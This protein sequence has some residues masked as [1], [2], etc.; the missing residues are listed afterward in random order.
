MTPFPLMFATAGLLAN[1]T[2]AY[3]FDHRP[4]QGREYWGNFTHTV[5]NNSHLHH[6]TDLAAEP[7]ADHMSDGLRMMCH[8]RHFRHVGEA[9][10]EVPIDGHI[11]S[12]DHTRM[13][14][15]CHDIT[16]ELTQ[17]AHK[18]SHYLPRLRV[19]ETP[20]KWATTGGEKF[21]T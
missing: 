17:L 1:T 3:I 18:D 2:D 21:D 20:S 14:A 15:G 8:L 16:A 19:P 9:R 13:W 4:T 12:E 6:A 5:R 7:S 11:P 10:G